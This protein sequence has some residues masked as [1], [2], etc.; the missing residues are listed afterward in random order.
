MLKRQNNILFI[1]LIVT[2]TALLAGVFYLMEYNFEVDRK[3][4]QSRQ[5][6]DFF[7]K[8]E[9][10]IQGFR[11][12]SRAYGEQI[13]TRENIE[14]LNKGVRADEE[15]VRSDYR[16]A[17]YKRLLPLYAEL[18]SLGFRQMHFHSPDNRSFLRMHRPEKFGDDLSGIRSSVER[19]NEAHTA[20]SGFEEGMIFN[21]YRFVYPVA[22]EGEHIGSFE[23]SISFKA[24]IDRIEFLF[25]NEYMNYQVVFPREIVEE[26]VFEEEL[27]NYFTW[28]VS[29]DFFLDKGVSS[30]CILSEILSE[31][32]LETLSSSFQTQ[33]A[34]NGAFAEIF[35][36]RGEQPLLLMSLP[37]KNFEDE[38]A[39]FFISIMPSENLLYLQKLYRLM[40]LVFGGITI[41]LF[42]ILL[43]LWR[44]NKRISNI[45]TFDT[46]TGL[47]NR[48]I[49][50]EF[51]LKA[52]N[53]KKRYGTDVSV[54]LLDIDDFK[55]VNDVYGHNVGDL[56][57]K[58]VSNAVIGSIRQSDI[59]GRWGGDEIIIVLPQTVRERALLLAERIRDL[60]SDLQFPELRGT[61]INASF[62]VLQ[63]PEDMADIDEVLR[64]V[65]E[66]LYKAKKKGKNRI[67]G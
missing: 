1:I 33:K 40:Y 17:L 5:I 31:G 2:L 3:N 63:V 24:V 7:H 59:T 53:R 4:Y 26:K 32:Q 55:R 18:E 51:L 16:E 47:Y 9:A 27:A 29:S 52:L 67:C 28:C 13:L 14:L 39:A 42:C 19:V 12:L 58:E 10:I 30:E 44:S 50:D 62:G 36:K 46:A 20:V 60:L 23:L 35:P 37:V 6:D 56:V 38:T 48:A 34:D 49:T 65:D 8:T 22:Y 11:D 15:A 45:A 25:P 54:I 57:L 66:K 21:G 61:K 64:R 43:L 41:I